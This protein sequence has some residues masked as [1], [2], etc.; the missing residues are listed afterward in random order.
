MG[1]GIIGTVRLAAALVFAIPVA[2]FGLDYLL[3]GRTLMGAGAVGIAVLMVV[4]E[5]YLTKPTDVPGK[6]AEKAVGTV[7]E[8]EDEE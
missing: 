1:R 2:M 3:Q 4:M 5:E 7:V 6:A 8:T